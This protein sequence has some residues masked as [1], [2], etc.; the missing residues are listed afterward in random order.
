M[1]KLKKTSNRRANLW[2]SILAVLITFVGC[3]FAEETPPN[4]IVIFADDLGYN[5][6]SCYGGAFPTP[7]IDQF[8]SEGLQTKDCIVPANVCSPSRASLL[9]GRYPMRNGYPLCGPFG[10]HPEEV[11]IPKLLKTA[12]YK[13]LAV[14]KWH[15]GFH[16]EGSHPLDA[17]FDEYLGFPHNYLDSK[18]KVDR[19]LYNGR[20]I[21]K[22]GVEFEEITPFYNR[23]VAS[24]IEREKDGPF[25]IYLAHQIAHTPILPNTKFK[26]STKKGI[27]AD[28]VAELDHSV[29]TVVDAV[30][31]AGIEDNTLIVFL[32]DNGHAGPRP[33]EHLSGRKFTTM[34]GG[35]R[36]PCLFRWPKMI[37]AGR[38]TD[39]TISSMDLLPLFCELAGV[40]LPDDR[41]LDG[42]DISNIVFEG[43]RV[44]P[45]E[46]LY[47][48]NGQNLQAIRKGKWKLHL[49]RTKKD[50]PYW[51]QGANGSHYFYELEEPF[52]VNLETDLYEKKNVAQ[53]HPDVVQELMS[54][55]T[56]TREELGDSRVKGQ[57]QRT[58]WRGPAMSKGGR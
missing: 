3:L 46:H 50:Q 35:H 57:D 5:D 13:S 55:A 11:T 8:A 14:G 27:I 9:T 53:Q 17:G 34:E 21:I 43:E 37:E 24:F 48:Y 29:G 51:G 31:A 19:N 32:S 36:I 6:V 40:A 56:Q 28:F 41:K 2:E 4:I 58:S 38:I 22:E 26:G 42:F 39:T 25:F 12:G 47:Y 44:S 15:L 49:P 20:E 1:M 7:I 45:H 52:L 54:L 30:K 18:G 10:L 23:E 16:T 33:I